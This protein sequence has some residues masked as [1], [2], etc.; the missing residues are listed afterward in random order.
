MCL[1]ILYIFYSRSNSFLSHINFP[2][3][4]TNLL[5]NHTRSAAASHTPNNHRRRLPE[6]RALASQTAIL[7]HMETP[8]TS[9]LSS[10]GKT[11]APKLLASSYRRPSSSRTIYGDR[12]IPSRSSSNFALFNLPNSSSTASSDDSH[13]AYTN[14]LKLAL[15]GPECV[16]GFQPLTPEKSS[17]GGKF[18]GR[19]SSDGSVLQ[20]N[21][22]NCNIFKYKTETRKSLH[23]LSPFGFDDQLPGVSHS[24]VKAP[25]KVPRSPYKV[26]FLILCFQGFEVPILFSLL[27]FAD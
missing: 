22:P 8:S 25:R 21:P 18:G 4:P 11:S 23:S 26:G 9:T 7:E 14:L 10:D 16:G 17:S 15:F 5:Q 13:S 6:K 19:S 1:Y 20:I 2:G 27:T 24:P 3:N 12:F